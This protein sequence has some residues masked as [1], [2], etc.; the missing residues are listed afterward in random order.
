VG[1]G[2]C[3]GWDEE[4]DEELEEEEEEEEEL[5]LLLSSAS[6]DPAGPGR[7][8]VVVGFIGREKCYS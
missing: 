7:C 2:R 6:S 8:R 5:L 4:D 1:S 3:C